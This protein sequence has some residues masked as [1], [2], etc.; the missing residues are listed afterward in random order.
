MLRKGPFHY[1]T[2]GSN[3]VRHVEKG[4]CVQSRVQSR[5]QLLSISI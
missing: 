4:S 5:M 2:S 3:V 1:V